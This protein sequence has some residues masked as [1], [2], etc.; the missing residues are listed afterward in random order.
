MRQVKSKPVLAVQC[1]RCGNTSLKR[2]RRPGHWLWSCARPGCGY[3][4]EGN[5]HAPTKA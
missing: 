1:P 3:H 2:S 5:K 4:T